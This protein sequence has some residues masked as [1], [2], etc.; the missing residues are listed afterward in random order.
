MYLGAAAVPRGAQA[1]APPPAP[2]VSYAPQI[3][4]NAATPG[5]TQVN[6]YPN[7]VVVAGTGPNN[8]ATAWRTA[9]YPQ[10]GLWIADSGF[11]IAPI[12]RTAADLANTTT[13]A[14][15]IP[16]Y[17][18]SGLSLY[19]IP[20]VSSRVL[21]GFV[22]RNPPPPVYAGMDLVILT[23]DGGQQYIWYRQDP[24]TGYWVPDHAQ[25][26]GAPGSNLFTILLVAGV[27]IVAAVVTYGASVGWF[28][29][30]AAV[31]TGAAAGGTAAAAGG[32][33]AAAGGITV[34]TAA[35]YAGTAASLA[36]SIAKIAGGGGA[37]GQQVIVGGVPAAGGY[38]TPAGSATIPAGTTLI[39]PD[40]TTTVTTSGGALPAGYQIAAAATGAGLP[41]Y[42]PS[43]PTAGG[44]G[45]FPGADAGAQPG[46]APAAAAA[47][48]T[49]FMPAAIGAGVVLLL[50]MLS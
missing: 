47:A 22:V 31:D 49:W 34:G 41:S 3:V 30:A 37:P 11:G 42:L 39:A 12:Y 45:F 23:K 27:I 8:T 9:F 32:G 35:G 16:Y 7:G 1:I 19:G 10:L 29:G 28:G 33:A 50:S 2:A 44:G 17:R 38:I 25:G 6:P 5:T 14:N 4:A 26:T 40:G 20:A 48:P 21:E 18:H 43:A 46:L 36:T 24:S 13:R 15:L